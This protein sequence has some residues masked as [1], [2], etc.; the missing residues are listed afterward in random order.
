M[1]QPRTLKRLLLALLSL[2]I[3]WQAQTRLSSAIQSDGWILY[4]LAIILFFVAF[5]RT[6]V[7]QLARGRA[8]ATAPNAR[9]Q[10]LSRARWV[11]L[12]LSILSTLISIAKFASKDMPSMWLFHLLA[13]LLLIAAFAP[14]PRLRRPAVNPS[15]D[16]IARLIPVLVIMALA[17]FA[18]L[19]QIDQFPFGTWSDEASNSLEA[20]HI[21]QDAQYRPVYV[22]STQMPAH[23]DYLVALSFSL[24][25]VSTTAIRYITTAFGVLS[26]LFAYLLF[27]RWFGERIGLVAAALLAVLRYSLTFSRFGMQGIATP[28][29]ELVLLYFFDRAL[30]RKRLSDV[31]WMGLT[32]GF[33]LTFYIAYRLFP[34]AL[35]LFGAAAVVVALLRY[36]RARNEAPATSGLASAVYGF[37]PQHLIIFVLA[38]LIALAPV[39]QFAV[40]NSD[41]FFGLPRTGTVSI[42]EKRDEP[43]LG[44]ALWSNFTRHLLMFNVQGDRN[45]LHN[46]S[47]APMLDPL[48]GMLFVLG[49]ALAL[50]RWRDPPNVLM[51]L[52]FFVMLLGGVLSADS[53]APQS[54]RSIG[55]MPSLIYFATIPLAAIGLEVARV[56]RSKPKARRESFGGT[57]ASEQSTVNSEQLRVNGEQSPTPNVQPPMSN[58]QYPTSNVQRPLTQLE[59]RMGAFRRTTTQR[60]PL[61]TALPA[62]QRSFGDVEPEP[63]KTA[64]KRRTSLTTRP[65]AYALL[66]VV[67]LAA[68]TYSNFDVFFNKQ[69]NS[70]VAIAAQPPSEQPASATVPSIQ[71]APPAGALT[72]KPVQTIGAQGSGPGQFQQPHAVAVGAN[73]RIFVADTGNKRV[74]ILG[75]DGEFITAIEGGEQK[76]ADPFDVVVT[77]SGELIVLDSEDGWL[78]RFDQD[79]KPLGRMAGPSAQLFHPRGFSIDAQ[80]N[81]YVADTGG[82]RIVKLSSDGQ[83][84]QV[85]GAKGTGKGQFSQ[86]SAAVMDDLGVLFATDVLN[87]RIEAF[88]VDGK[89]LFDFPIPLADPYNGPH[90]AVAPD[91]TLLVTAPEP[92]KLQRYGRDGKLLGEWGG[93]GQQ[94]G[95][96]RQPTGIR[97]YDNT[98]WIADTLN[99]RVQKWEIQ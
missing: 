58:L 8:N 84:L 4:S 72:L 90:I 21:L 92:H 11:L 25:G 79:G 28:T 49:L 99:H 51:L 68:I 31:A 30:E 65:S 13:M 44:K 52:I 12:A 9:E 19:W 53:E 93:P 91:Q 24:F 76:F 18:R 35:A 2:I 87:K 43:D 60:R 14:I 15:Q 40:Q 82:A 75:A 37:N 45:P 23:F 5:G 98:L 42:F 34:V 70:L 62:E 7:A 57:R 47:N 63:S 22:D 39:V 80:N 66:L 59:M 86:P 54:L 20:A 67:L 33:G 6:S 85:F 69:K 94:L 41:V 81:F 88:G 74:Q 77:S 83:R 73:G 16:T 1:K 17:L 3:A 32:L 29:F 61:P 26:V 64:D 10:G 89:F 46:L 96:F 27:R 48:M 36:R 55:V 50:W 56:F 95:Q 71:S 38:T 97:M 78:F